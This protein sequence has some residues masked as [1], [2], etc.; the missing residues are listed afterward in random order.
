MVYIDIVSPQESWLFY[1]HI[2][3]FDIK[4]LKHKLI[5]HIWPAFSTPAPNSIGEK[6]KSIKAI[7]FLNLLWMDHFCWRMVVN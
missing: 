2:I 3:V 6:E 5:F 1:I 7:F 4:T